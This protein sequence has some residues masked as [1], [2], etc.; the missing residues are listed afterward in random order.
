MEND[1]TREKTIRMITLNLGYN[2]MSNLVKGSESDQVS[3]CQQTYSGSQGWS[4]RRN[5]SQCSLNSIDFLVEADI[6]CL[7]ELNPR[8][9]PSFRNALREQ[10][11]NKGRVYYC[12][13]NGPVMI[14]ADART[15]GIGEEVT[16]DGFLFYDPILPQDKR[17]FQM[18][19]FPQERLLIGNLHA[20]HNIN[21][22]RA[23]QDAFDRSLYYLMAKGIVDPRGSG[24]TEIEKIALLG[25]FNDS[26]GQLLPNQSGSSSSDE[27]EKLTFPLGE[28]SG[29]VVSIPVTSEMVPKTCCRDA[30][31]AFR[32]DYIMLGTHPEISMYVD[33]YGVPPG[34]SRE[35]TPI[36][37]HDPLM[38]VISYLGISERGYVNPFRK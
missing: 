14:I 26:D 12:S 36:S 9:E 8:S 28:D 11:Q 19:Y 22:H 18:V 3:F 33:Y 6:I 13:K 25:D 16:P 31:F 15:I 21:L 27:E 17:R 38:A 37:D 32:G 29:L 35:T 7:Q 5:L 23:L 24:A 2:V 34:Y 20:P 1:Q 30:N 4:P 10:A